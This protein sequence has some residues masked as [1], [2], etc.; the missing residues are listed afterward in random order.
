V[1]NWRTGAVWNEQMD[2]RFMISFAV[3]NEIT[4]RNE[5]ENSANP[6][7]G[8]GNP[9]RYSHSPTL[10]YFRMSFPPL[11]LTSSV[12]GE[13]DAETPVRSTAHFDPSILWQAQGRQSHVRQAHPLEKDVRSLDRFPGH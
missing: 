11:T 5:N 9:L 1:G 10:R 8:L 2:C 3:C 6:S 4:F 13:L 12:T 7:L